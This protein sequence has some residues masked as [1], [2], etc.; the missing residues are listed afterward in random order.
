MTTTATERNRPTAS[1]RRADLGS[2]LRTRRERL[3]PEEFGLPAGSRRR[4]PGLRREEVAQLAGVGVTWYTWLEQGRPIRASVQ[5][6]DAVSRTLRLDPAEHEHLYRL[7]GVPR[8]PAGPVERHPPAELL[9]ILD[10]L[11][12]LPACVLT[13]RFDVLAANAAYIAMF[14][15]LGT[16]PK[17]ILW[18]L[19]SCPYC[20]P[21]A[22]ADLEIPRMV[23]RFRAAYARHS[24]EPEWDSLVTDL[25]AAS[26]RFTELWHTH[27]VAAHETGRKVFNH[28]RTGTMTFNATSLA[29]H[30]AADMRLS[31]Y[32]PVDSHTASVIT[33][34]LAGDLAI[35]PCPHG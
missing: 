24:G 13:E 22:E 1:A 30:P 12:P 5:V 14:P 9:T 4:T 27:D 19:F 21:F 6:L 33:R 35:P 20:D 15:T 28:P 23:A 11:N 34:L 18:C 3:S 7:A 25:Q 29:V 31:V 2:F 8:P 17:N 10:A 26:P 16:A 32:T